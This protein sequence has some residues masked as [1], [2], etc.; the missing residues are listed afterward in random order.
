MSVHFFRYALTIVAICLSMNMAKAQEQNK[1]ET[2]TKEKEI[3][4]PHHKLGLILGHAHV[5]QGRDADGNKQ[6][7]DMA[8]WGID[9]DYQFNRRWSVGLHTDLIMEKFKVESYSGSGDDIIERNYPIAPALVFGYKLNHHWM[10][11]LGTGAEFSREGTLFL[12][13]FGVEYG[14]EIR[15]GWE[16]AG[17]ASYDI[18]WDAYDTWVLGIG[19]SKEFGGHK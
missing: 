7:L 6:A 9:Y 16:V 18:K 10:L 11:Q 2:G 15:N 1:V 12:N 8:S 17:N 14:V 19:I 5:F 4:S 3:F 13:R